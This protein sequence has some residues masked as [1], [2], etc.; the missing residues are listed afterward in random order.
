M[1]K[2]LSKLELRGIQAAL[3]YF[4]NEYQRPFTFFGKLF[5][6]QKD[7]F[8]IFNQNS[9][10]KKDILGKYII[11]KDDF[12]EYFERKGVNQFEFYVSSGDML[13]WTPLPIISPE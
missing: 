9:E 5:G 2:S 6:L 13:E 12:P 8:V 11:E 1:G 10:Y 3:N 7:Y 4:H